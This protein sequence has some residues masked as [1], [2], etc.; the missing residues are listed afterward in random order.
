MIISGEGI[1][2][3]VWRLATGLIVRGASLDESKTSVPAVRPPQPVIQSVPG[4]EHSPQSRAIPL[5][6]LYG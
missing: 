1:A 4:H 3:S 6:P 5:L 2:Q